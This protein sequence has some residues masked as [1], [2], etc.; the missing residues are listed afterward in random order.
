M[1]FRFKTE[2][3]FH[4]TLFLFSFVFEFLG[5]LGIAILVFYLF[6][7][8]KV[9]LIESQIVFEMCLMLICFFVCEIHLNLN[10]MV[11]VVVFSILMRFQYRSGE[12]EVDRVRYINLFS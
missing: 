10:G 3:D 7:K 6:N 9:W 12:V 4:S 8:L 5:G 1:F 2:T 11:S